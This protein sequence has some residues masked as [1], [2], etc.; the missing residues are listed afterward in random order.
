M[1]MTTVEGEEEEV[2]DDS[3]DLTIAHSR[4]P[5]PSPVDPVPPSKNGKKEMNS[6]TTVG[7]TVVQSNADGVDHPRGRLSLPSTS[8]APPH[9][10]AI[11]PSED[12]TP[13]AAAATATALSSSS[14]WADATW[15]ASASTSFASVVDGGT[16]A[17]GGSS[18]V[19]GTYK[20]EKTKTTTTV[21]I[22]GG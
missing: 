4:V 9:D 18:V 5:P 17:G 1:G 11:V 19:D 21:R 3:G 16:A 6:L 20:N 7:G 13:A 22:G 2:N 12:A 10:S 14:S 15:Y 8:F